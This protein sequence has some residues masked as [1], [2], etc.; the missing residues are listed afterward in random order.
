ML[1]E[2]EGLR[3]HLSSA[4]ATGYK[5]VAKL[6][7]GRFEARRAA[8]GIKFCLGRFGTAVEA[9]VAYARAVEEAAA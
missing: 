3:L 2:A 6:P 9:A 7:S 8:D 4:A 1:A 5:G